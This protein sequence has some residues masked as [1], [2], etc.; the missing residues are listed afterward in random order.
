MRGGI[1]VIIAYS[2]SFTNLV[3]E[4]AFTHAPILNIPQRNQQLYRMAIPED[5]YPRSILTYR[6]EV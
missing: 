1:L 2:D 3:A 4:M 6:D 5:G